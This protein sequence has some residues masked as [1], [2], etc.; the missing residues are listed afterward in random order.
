VDVHQ[1]VV[2]NLCHLGHRG[3]GRHVDKG[4]KSVLGALLGELAEAVQE[5]PGQQVLEADLI[6]PLDGTSARLECIVELNLA[7]QSQLKAGTCM[8]ACMQLGAIR[9]EVKPKER[10]WQ[11]GA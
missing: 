11:S 1:R 4:E 6:D 9:E 3:G 8:H 10:V 2:A 5:V 7:R